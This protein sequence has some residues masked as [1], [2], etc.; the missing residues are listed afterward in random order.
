MNNVVR[1][2]RKKGLCSEN[3]SNESCEQ[4]T[5]VIKTIYGPV[6]G[7]FAQYMITGFVLAVDMAI[8]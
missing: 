3:V 1:L 7:L 5:D 8:W 4:A 2:E 6:P